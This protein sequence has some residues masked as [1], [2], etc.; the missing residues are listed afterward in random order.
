[1]R[2]PAAI[3]AAAFLAVAA[4]G[5]M[6]SEADWRERYL[7]KELQ[8]TEASNRL[9]EERNAHAAAVAQLEQAR[10]RISTLEREPLAGSS[11]SSPEAA[12]PAPGLDDGVRNLRGAGLDVRQ[13]ADG[14]IGVTL[15]A[16]VTFSP[17]SRDLTSAGKKSLDQVAKELQGSFAG[18]PVRIEG[19]TDSDPIR[20]SGFKDNWEL[21]SER[22]L[23][24]VRYLGS[25]GV[26]SE[27]LLSVSRGDTMPVADNKSDKGKARNRRVEVIILVPRG[28]TMSK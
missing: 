5:C 7:E 3:G 9:S 16:D 11:G 15:P 26:S 19:H 20:K 12:A 6:S 21:G 2:R 23:A 25:V 18:Y 13:T 22:A 17:G 1:M 8:A 14:D 28:S 10:N 4:T 27:R 24:A